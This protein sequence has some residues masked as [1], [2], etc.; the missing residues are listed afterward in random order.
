MRLTF[1]DGLKRKFCWYLFGVG[2]PLPNWSKPQNSDSSSSFSTTGGSTY[3]WALPYSQVFKPQEL[4]QQTLY[5]PKNVDKI[6]HPF[7]F[8][9]LMSFSPDPQC[10]GHSNWPPTTSFTSAKPQIRLHIEGRAATVKAGEVVQQ[11]TLRMCALGTGGADGQDLAKWEK[12]SK[13]WT[14]WTRKKWRCP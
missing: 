1:F 9:P 4:P 8:H 3:M 12:V 6:A 10:I 11:L 7:H 13:S 2:C 5:T 14:Q